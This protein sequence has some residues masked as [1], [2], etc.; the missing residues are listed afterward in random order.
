MYT[1][2]SESRWRSGIQCRTYIRRQ[3]P[4][5]THLPLSL[6][7]SSGGRWT[8]RSSFHLPSSFCVSCFAGGQLLLAK[9][10]YL[11]HTLSNQLRTSSA[12]GADS[13]RL[14]GQMVTIPSCERWCSPFRPRRC[15]Q[16]PRECVSLATV[17]HLTGTAFSGPGRRRP[18]SARAHRGYFATVVFYR[19][20]QAYLGSPP[21]LF[22]YLRAKGSVCSD[23]MGRF[24]HPGD[25]SLSP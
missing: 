21:V 9:R 18:Y 13:T 2:E 11:T 22:A 25:R 7:I 24:A 12:L 10:R 4:C 6:R 1:R 15:C 8:R 17:H 16:R 23:H 19:D 20:T 3:P 5:P 14:S